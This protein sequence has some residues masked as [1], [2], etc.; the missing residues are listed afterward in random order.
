MGL[1][2]Q[3]TATMFVFL[4]LGGRCFLTVL[5][6]LMIFLPPSSAHHE[7]T[8]RLENIVAHI[9]PHLGWHQLCED[10]G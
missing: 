5:G 3:A 9:A 2:L 8:E 4:V 10:K 6:E 1:P 7:N